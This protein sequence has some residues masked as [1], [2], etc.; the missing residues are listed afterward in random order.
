VKKGGIKFYLL[1]LILLVSCGRDLEQAKRYSEM[2]SECD[3]IIAQTNIILKDQRAKSDSLRKIRDNAYSTK[4]PEYKLSR[5]EREITN[6]AKIESDVDAIRKH[7]EA[8]KL[9]AKIGEKVNT[10]MI[11]YKRTYVNYSTTIQVHDE[12]VL[13]QDITDGLTAK[14]YIS[15]YLPKK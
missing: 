15:K 7:L 1:I 6:T 11:Y 14:Q 2:K 8:I 10:R 5:I 4:T 9:F 12:N 3:S 13:I